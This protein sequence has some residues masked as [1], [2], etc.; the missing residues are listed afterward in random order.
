MGLKIEGKE[1]MND[2]REYG[3]K[4]PKDSGAS[5]LPTNMGALTL[6]LIFK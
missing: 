3:V 1:L 4:R 2:L 5:R 6:L